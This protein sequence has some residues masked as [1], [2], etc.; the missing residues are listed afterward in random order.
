MTKP[1]LAGLDIGTS[2]IRCVLFN[3]KGNPLFNY[4]IKTPTVKKIDGIYNPVD[5]IYSIIIKILKKVFYFSKNKDLLIK[6]ISIS[7]VGEAGV[8]VDNNLKALIDIIPWYDQRTENIR[9][10]FLHKNKNFNIYKNTGLN[11]DHFYSAYKILWIKKNKLNI[12]KKIY[13]WLPV[14]D[15]YSMR[16]TGSISTDYSQAMRTLL[17]DPKKLKWSKIMI[18]KFGIK[19]NILPEII[20]AGDKKGIFNKKIKKILGINYDCI[21]GA[22]G[23]DHFVGIYG[24]GG[25][26]K[27]TI[28]NS[29]GSAEAIS[30]NTDKYLIN[31]KLK[32]G[33]FIS[34]VF[35]TKE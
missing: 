8:P 21:V 29:L 28:V 30:I 9:N 5:E 1:V 4:S 6:S 25:F 11:S 23:H 24:L 27:N 33:K 7:S 14:N 15:Y 16:L 32:N 3:I 31:N 20:N 18:K 10:N 35:K 26:Y 22:G 12:Y 13:K 19:Q 34:G 17:F 2:K